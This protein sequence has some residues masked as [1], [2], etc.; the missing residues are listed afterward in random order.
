[1]ALFGMDPTATSQPTGGALRTILS[2][3]VPVSVN[4]NEPDSVVARPRPAAPNGTPLANG[5]EFSANLIDGQNK[6]NSTGVYFST[7]QFGFG[8]GDT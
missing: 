6:A 4:M 5:A 8:T 7:T 3:P 1:M 2:R